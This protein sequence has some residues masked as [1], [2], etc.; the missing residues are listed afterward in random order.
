MQT[1]IKIEREMQTKIKIEREMQTKIKIESQRERE[2]RDSIQLEN[3]RVRAFRSFSCQE[4]TEMRTSDKT[5]PRQED[6]YLCKPAVS[7][8]SVIQCC[9]KESSSG[10]HHLWRE[11]ER[12][13]R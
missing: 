3:N 8:H 12:K 4:V 7:L 13:R 1:K 6:G 9:E 2:L 11:K 10:H 5:L